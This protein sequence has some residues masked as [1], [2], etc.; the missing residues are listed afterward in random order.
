[1]LVKSS[2]KKSNY[3]LTFNANT[4]GQQGDK[5][6]EHKLAPVCTGERAN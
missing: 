1:M 5:R 2:I 3:E 4:K 6:T